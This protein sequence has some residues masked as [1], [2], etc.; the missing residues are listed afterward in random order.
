MG[1][2]LRNWAGRHHQGARDALTE[3]RQH[4]ATFGAIDRRGE[5]RVAF[6]RRVRREVDVERDRARAGF[7]ET[8]DELRMLG[9]R[10]RP[11]VEAPQAFGVDRHNHEI[12]ARLMAGQREARVHHVEDGDRVQVRGQQRRGEGQAGARRLTVILGLWSRSVVPDARGGAPGTKFGLC[13]VYAWLFVSSTSA[14]LR[15][16]EAR[17]S[18]I[19]W[20]ATAISNWIQLR[21]GRRWRR[22]GRQGILRVGSSGRTACRS[23]VSAT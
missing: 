2:D 5:R 14:P 3:D 18:P 13:W 10:P 9:A 6:R 8:I 15:A 22:G 1:G 17:T 21:A 23:F 11:G 19:H 20:T 12:A 7:S 16:S 4:D